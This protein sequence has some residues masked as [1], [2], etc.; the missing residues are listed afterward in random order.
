MIRTTQSPNPG[1][2]SRIPD[3]NIHLLMFLAVRA[4]KWLAHPGPRNQPG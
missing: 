3:D 1:E 4:G 2:V